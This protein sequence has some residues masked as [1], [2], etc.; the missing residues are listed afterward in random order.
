ME[1]IN[2]KWLVSSVVGVLVIM[3]MF[4]VTKT[5][6]VTSNKT[7]GDLL[8]VSMPRPVKDMLIGFSLEG[9]NIIREIEESITKKATPQ[10]ALQNKK[11][12]AKVDKLKQAKMKAAREAARKQ[13]EIVKQ[14]EKAFQARVIEQAERYKQSLQLQEQEANQ[15]AQV[16]AQY[17]AV[18]AWQKKS[19]SQSTDNKAEKEVLTP[20]QWKSLILAQPTTENVKKMILAMTSG[21][22]D[23][24]TYL[25]IS[26]S[27]IKDNSQEKRKMGLWA[28]SSVY[29]VEAY[30]L[31]SHLMV[32][33]DTDLQKSL[34]D[35][36]Y[37]YNRPQTITILGQVLKAQDTVAASSAAELI[38]KA[39][40]ELQTQ[41]QSQASG[42]NQSTTQST[43]LTVTAYQNLIPTLKYVAAQNLNNLSQWAQTMLSQLQKIAT[44]A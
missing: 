37:N 8:Q 1:N 30:T 19:N 18:V 27:L 2:S 10:K 15:R 4:S 38:S 24:Q 34:T 40:Q 41:Q 33:A 28:L 13:A 6:N 12:K 42:S 3:L 32:D 44:T 9:R 35:Y 21:D 22:I 31:A 7:M 36:M 23:L 43:R 17:E 29:R 26:E 11:A 5:L 25:N 20:S 39:V 14:R 16:Q